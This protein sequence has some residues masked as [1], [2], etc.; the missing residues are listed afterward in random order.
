MKYLA[1]L[2]WSYAPSMLTLDHADFIKLYGKGALTIAIDKNSALAFIGACTAMPQR[3]RI[4]T[5]AWATIGWALVCAGLAAI[6]WLPWWVA[7]GGLLVGFL[8]HNANR[9]S[10]VSHIREAALESESLYLAALG[11]RV[12]SVHARMPEQLLPDAP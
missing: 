12:L 9:E 6:I 11:A 8:V 4:A 2:S 7:A 5:A 10:A 1:V 3:F